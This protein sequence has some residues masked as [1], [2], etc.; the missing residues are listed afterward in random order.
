VKLTQND[1]SHQPTHR[2]T[3]ANTHQALL[4]GKVDAVLFGKPGLRYYAARDGAGR[5]KMVGPEFNRNDVGFLFE[6]GDTLR[7]RV[8]GRLLPCARSQRLVGNEVQTRQSSFA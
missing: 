5:V 7:R 2:R 6:L 1:S 4:D 3:A 8:S